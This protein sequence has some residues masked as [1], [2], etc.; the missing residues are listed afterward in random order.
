MYTY[1]I[2]SAAH[3][4]LMLFDAPIAQESVTRRNR[5]NTPLQALTLLNDESQ[6]EFGAALAERIRGH[7]ED[8]DDRIRY[9][10]EICLARPPQAAER[11]RLVRFVAR[12]TD[13]FAT[14]SEA[15]DQTGETTAAAAAWTAAARVMINLDEFVTRQ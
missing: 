4:G 7:S 8:R 5:S 3:P 15:L 12:M 14:D 9:A 10:F 11:D 2:R 13:S 1:F 6:A